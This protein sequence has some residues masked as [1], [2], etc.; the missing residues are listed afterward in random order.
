MNSYKKNNVVIVILVALLFLVVAALVYF[1]YFL[2]E[3]ETKEEKKESLYVEISD[4]TIIT[5]LLGTINENNLHIIATYEKNIDNMNVLN[6]PQKLDI[7]LT[8][9]LNKIN[10]PYTNGIPIDLFDIYFK[11]T[12]R[13]TIY[14]DKININCDCGEV[15]YLYNEEDNKYVYNE[16]HLGH[17]YST[18]L[19]YYTK[20]IDAKKKNETYIV[21][22]SYVWNNYSDVYGYTNTGYASF[23]DA[24]SMNNSL[25]EIEV[26]DEL[27][28][29]EVDSYAI[30]EIETNYELYKDKLHK[31]T[32]TFEKVDNKYLLVNFD[33]E[34]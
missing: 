21:T 34:K 7:S 32:Y 5:E 15:L 22:V 29:E 24:S 20:V 10:D 1:F 4:E 27:P 33:Y 3:P 31:Y 12:F 11:N 14:W 9:I 19:P 23:T 17:G 2:E 30:K 26:P 16:E 13:T 28:N 18:V 25:F 8:S 6:T